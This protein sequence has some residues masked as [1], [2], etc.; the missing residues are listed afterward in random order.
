MIVIGMVVVETQKTEKLTLGC[1]HTLKRRRPAFARLDD[2]GEVPR[3]D[4]LVRGRASQR[5]VVR[6]VSQMD[7][8]VSSAWTVAF[9]QIDRPKQITARLG[10]PLSLSVAPGER[11]RGSEQE[12]PDE[13]ATSIKEHP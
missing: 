4:M 7:G 3:G 9:V 2:V 10:A 8:V 5:I 12:Q 6:P 1:A 13:H 11:Q